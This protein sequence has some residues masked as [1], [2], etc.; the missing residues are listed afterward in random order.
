MQQKSW[1]FF[2]LQL[3]VFEDVMCTD[4][5]LTSWAAISFPWS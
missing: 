4:E 1:L 3:L 5:V 2:C